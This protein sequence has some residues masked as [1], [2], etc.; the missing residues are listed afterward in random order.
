MIAPTPPRLRADWT[1]LVP[2]FIGLVLRAAAMSV[3]S[4]A[5]EDPDNYL[6]LARSVARGEGLAWKGRPTAY[7]PPLY[8]LMLAPIVRLADPRP[9][10]A[11]AVLHLIFGAATTWQATMAARRWGLGDRRA[12]AAGLI[13]ACDPVLVWQSRFIMTET[14]GALLVAA[15]VAELARPGFRGLLGGGLALG[16]SS[17]CRPSLLPGAGL[18]VAAALAVGPG[19]ARRRAAHALALSGII[20]VVLAPWALR[21]AIALG[22]PVWTTTHG[23]YTLALANNPTYFRDV[24]DSAGAEVWTGDDQWNWWDSV[25]RATAGMTEPEADRFLRD[26]VLRLVAERPRVFARAC[27]DRLAR[28]W[29][30]APAQPVYSA[31][32]RVA[33]AAWTGPLWAALLVGLLNRKAWRWPRIAAPAAILGLTMVHVFYWTDLRMRAPIVPAIALVAAAAELPIPGRIRRRPPAPSP[34]GRTER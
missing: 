29:G 17:L 6:P 24:L 33:S 8:P 21:N 13:V 30:L 1:L 11:I 15:A 31:R 9:N 3:G 25:N 14:L 16:L 28:F 7:R 10:P 2:L 5:F 18:V 26:S 22:E 27:L 12:L 19:T 34:S 20:L 32:V 23:G 4:G